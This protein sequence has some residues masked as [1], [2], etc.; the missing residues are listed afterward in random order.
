MDG[1][2]NCRY[3]G[4]LG[5]ARVEREPCVLRNLMIL[6]EYTSYEGWP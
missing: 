3:S 6:N 5:L 4:T 1:Y 2:T